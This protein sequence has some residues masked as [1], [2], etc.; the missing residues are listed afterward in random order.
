MTSR[1]RSSDFVVSDISSH[2]TKSIVSSRALFFTLPAAGDVG[3]GRFQVKNDE[4]AKE[5][6][7]QEATGL[8]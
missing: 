3:S 6:Y 4:S 1:T 8:C 5:I 7:N 2:D